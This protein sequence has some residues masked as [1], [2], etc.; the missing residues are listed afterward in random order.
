MRRRSGL[1]ISVGDGTIR[2]AC[3]AGDSL[4]WSLEGE[5]PAELTVGDALRALLDR[6]PAASVR[7]RPVVIVVDASVVQVRPL[8]GFPTSTDATMRSRVLEEGARRW[9]LL[10]AGGLVTVGPVDSS[11]SAPWGAAYAR[12]TVDELRA[13]VESMGAVEIRCIPARELRDAALL[14]SIR[15]AS[16]TVDEPATATAD[17][18]SRAALDA[19]WLARDRRP[20]PLELGGATAGESTVSRVR[21]RV[22]AGVA[23]V[24]AFAAVAAYP[25]ALLLTHARL[26]A[27]E[28]RMAESY[29]EIAPMVD[30]AARLSDALDAVAR[31]Q[32]S[33]RAWISPIEAIAA[34]LP[35]GTAAVTLRADS[36]N[37]VLV[38]LGPR[39][40]AAVDLLE[41]IPGIASPTLLGPVTTEAI[42]GQLMERATIGFTHG[43]MP[44]R[45]R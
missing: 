36:V 32:L 41:G 11:D 22:A 5:V 33:R 9:F 43:T 25:A 10:R 1:G 24:A 17:P 38:V 30:S 3:V 35:T 8:D 7:G 27:D 4:E 15:G 16:D 31:R 23:A 42:A 2:V 21:A 29:A 44:R 13:V 20:V 18:A 12:S 39:A 19:A 14:P 45:E 28:A 26:T 37:A 40:G 34:A 6:A